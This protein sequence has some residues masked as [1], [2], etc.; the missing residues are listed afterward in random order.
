MY[1]YAS[2]NRLLLLATGLV[3][4][5][6]GITGAVVTGPVPSAYAV[7]RGPA[8]HSTC[9]WASAS[10]LG[11]QSPAS[12]AGAVVVKMT[13]AEKAAFVTIRDGGGVENINKGVPSLCV[14]ALT[15]SDGPNGIAGRMTGVTQL[16]AAI[17]IGASFDPTLAR[18]TGLVVGTEARA[19]GIDVV[20]GPGLNLARVPFSGRIFESYGEDPFLTSLLG[21]ANI[22]GIQSTGVMAMAKHFAA[23]TQETA[24]ARLRQVVTPR[25]LA[26]LY[27]APF[28]AAVEQAKVASVMCSSGTLNGKQDCSD[29]Y[30]Y[31]TLK[32]W[33]F[34]GFVRSDIRAAPHPARA[35]NVGLDLIKPASASTIV[36]LVRSKALN[37]SALNRAVRSL[38]TEMFRYGLIA[39][40]RFLN[41]ASVATTQGH[42]AVALRAAEQSVVLLKNSRNALPLSKRITSVAVIGADAA[43]G[44]LNTGFGSSRVIAPFVVTPL[45]GLRASLGAK[46]QVTYAA[47]APASLNLSP[48]SDSGVVSAALAPITKGKVR[49]SD[50]GNDLSIEAAA[51]VTNAI[52]TASKPGTGRGWS[53]WRGRLRVK[54]SGLY[55]VSVRQIGDTWLYLNGREVLA[56]AGLHNPTTMTSVLKLKKGKHYEFKVRWYTVIRHPVPEFGVIAASRSIDVAVAAA[57]RAQV[58]V[59][60]AGQSSTEGA[61]QTSLNL[62]GDQNAL[63]EAVAAVN[64]RTIV[65]LNTGGPVLMPWLHEVRGVLEA[66]YPGEQGGAAIAA[67]L[68]GAVDPSG[69]LPVTFPAS[70]NAQPVVSKNLFPGVNDTVSFGSAATALEV[71]YRWYETNHVT[72][73]F[74]FGFGLDYTSFRLTN[75]TVR[76][77]ASKVVI[78][79]TVSNTGH[80]RGADV[81]QVYVKDP[82]AAGEPPDQLRAFTRVELGAQSS[83][84]LTLDVPIA[85]LRIYEHGNLVTVPGDY[86]IGIGESSRYLPIVVHVRIS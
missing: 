56:S 63:I 51:N 21:V 81:V 80:Q 78:Q 58:A 71:G 4:S 57:R 53:H 17:G 33:G 3:L 82:K 11:R 64:P 14:P 77:V 83:R 36:N 22:E 15:L 34:T 12:L 43:S 35:F 60:F 25:A 50:M 37:V 39:H 41:V 1:R 47:G 54:K 67:V 65:V 7:T 69:R 68:T 76:R 86:A 18:A 27:N 28:E 26:E 30:V 44:F 79:V 10:L 48:L 85:S 20:Q 31:S 45:A 8:P 6:S 40:P 84:R 5:A 61:D 23:Y 2:R 13:L 52:V 16:P 38:L 70:T 59:V 46:V 66:W 32:S 29:Y 24:R 73:L 19:K 72:P 74:P 42:A 49:P 9:P 75:P 62:P 55:E